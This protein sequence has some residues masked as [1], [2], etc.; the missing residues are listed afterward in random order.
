MKHFPTITKEIKNARLELYEIEAFDFTREAW[1][2]R[3]V[4]EYKKL[5]KKREDS[6]AT[7]KVSTRKLQHTKT[8]KTR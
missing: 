7:S 1:L 8:A 4:E 3:R 6:L 5:K 2:A